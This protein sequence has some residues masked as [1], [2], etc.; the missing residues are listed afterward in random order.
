MPKAEK[1]SR[2]RDILAGLAQGCAAKGALGTSALQTMGPWGQGGF[3]AAWARLR[4]ERRSPQRRRCGQPGFHPCTSPCTPACPY[5]H[6]G[7]GLAACL[8]S[9]RPHA[10]GLGHCR[11]L[12]DGR[13]AKAARLWRSASQRRKWMIDDSERGTGGFCTPLAEDLELE[14]ERA[15]E[16]DRRCLMEA[17][18]KAAAASPAL[19]DAVAARRLRG[20]PSSPAGRGDAS[21]SFLRASRALA[22]GAGSSEAA[23]D[24]LRAHNRGATHKA[25]EGLRQSVAAV[26]ELLCALGAQREA[27]PADLGGRVHEGLALFL[28]ATSEGGPCAQRA[29]RAEYF[30]LMYLYALAAGDGGLPACDSLATFLPDLRRAAAILRR[31]GKRAGRRRRVLTDHQHFVTAALRAL[32]HPRQAPLF[33]AVTRALDREARATVL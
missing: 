25:G 4:K 10:C 21:G 33:R 15:R 29:C 32:Q 8:R 30:A 23:R 12:P 2:L 5:V 3:Y 22:A 27:A 20:R 1:A 16:A 26:K 31:Q 11:R 17:A 9:G 24:L 7:A 18:R 14:A 19:Q 6:L 13:C 28:M